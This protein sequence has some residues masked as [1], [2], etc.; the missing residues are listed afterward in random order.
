[1]RMEGH[2]WTPTKVI[3]HITYWAF[4]SFPSSTWRSW[5]FSLPF[6]SL[7]LSSWMHVMIISSDIPH[8]YENITYQ[9]LVD[10]I[11]PIRMYMKNKCQKRCIQCYGTINWH[12]ILCF[13]NLHSEIDVKKNKNKNIKSQVEIVEWW[14]FIWLTSFPQYKREK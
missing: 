9:Y 2:G 13:N 12:V 6:P 1:M 5:K 8:P 10:I 14:R 7:P 4:Y 11:K 3:R